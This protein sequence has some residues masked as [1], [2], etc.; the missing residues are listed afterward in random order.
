M[1]DYI[2]YPDLSFFIKHPPPSK[3][4]RK[5]DISTKNLKKYLVNNY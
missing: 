5:E 1:I 4:Y 3:Y 2:K